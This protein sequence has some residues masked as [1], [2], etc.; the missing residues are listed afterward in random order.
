MANLLKWA[1]DRAK[2]VE[3]IAQTAEHGVSRAAAQVNPLD[4]GR[5]WQNNAP[6]QA[7]QGSV[8]QQATHNGL[9]NV[10]GNS[11]VKPAARI[12]F[13][14][15][16]QAYN[17]VVAPTFKLPKMS[18]GQAPAGHFATKQLG[19]TGKLS[20]SAGDII[21]S[22]A[23][24]LMPGS[25]KVVTGAFE[26]VLP[27][28]VP[29]IAS[30]AIANSGVG[31]VGGGVNNVGTQLSSGN[32]H[33]A[34]DIPKALEQGAKPG[35]LL[36]FGGTLAAPVLKAGAVSARPVIKKAATQASLANRTTA[37]DQLTL[38]DL[39]N[40]YAGT[41]P[42]KPAEYSKTIARARGVGQRHGVDITS[43][44]Q[45]DRMNAVNSILDKV[46]KENRATSE[47]G[48]AKAGDIIPDRAFGKVPAQSPQTLRTSMQGKS[49]VSR[50]V[51]SK[52]SIHPNTIRA[53]N[54]LKDNSAK[55]KADY[56]ARVKKE[57]GAENVVSGDAAKFI[58]PGFKD[59]SANSLH[60]HDPASKFAKEHYKQLLADP[61][62]KHKPV[63]IMSGGTGAGKTSALKR[64]GINLN[65][66]AAVVDTNLAKKTSA[67][68]RVTP[69]INSGRK[70][71]IYHV[72]REPVDAY[73]NGVIKRAYNGH[74]AGRI[75]TPSIHA[76]THAGSIANRLAD[77]FANH[78]NVKTSVIDNTS[79][80]GGI[81]GVDFLKEL[82]YTKTKIESSVNKA[83]DQ[84]RNEGKI[85][86]EQY[87]QLKGQETL[88]S[89]DPRRNGSNVAQEPST[90]H[91]QVTK[92]SLNAGVPS[93]K[94]NLALPEIL[95]QKPVVKQGRGVS[96]TNEISVAKPRSLANNTTKAPKGLTQS[97]QSSAEFSPEFKVAIS[98][99]KNPSKLAEKALV[100]DSSLR[101]L[102]KATNDVVET[103]AKPTRQLTDQDAAN[104][105][106]VMKAQDTKGNTAAA[107]QIHDLL[108]GHGEQS[109]QFI[110]AFK[111]VGNRTPEGML[112]GARK[113]L[114]KAGIT[115][116]KDMETSIKQQIN[117]I[118]KAK[119]GSQE[120]DL[121]VHNLISHVNSFIPSSTGDRLV[122]FWRAGLLTSPI[123]TAGNLIGNTGEAIV[124][125]AW[126]NPVG[127][128]ADLAQSLI[129]GKRTKTMAGGQVSG[130]AKG[131]ADSKLYLK[132]G[133]D[134][135]NP[136]NKFEQRRDLNYST[137]KVGKA[138]GTYV[139][140]VYR[141][142]GAEDKPFRQAAANQAAGDLAKADAI[143]LGLKG[144]EREAYIA[145]ARSNPEWKPQTFKTQNTSQ[146]AG[147]F[148]VFG[149]E[150][151]LG[152]AAAALKNPAT[153]GG[154]TLPTSIAQFIVP[155]SQVPASIA[156]RILHRSDLGATEVINQIMRIRHGL[157]YDQR[158]VSE[159]IGNGT[160]GPAVIGAGYALSKTGNITGNYPT[161][162]KEQELW[163][164]QGKQ[165]NSVKIGD[166]WYSMNYLQ[167]F[168]AL[169]GIGAQA[170]KDD[171]AG[172][173]P[174][175]I[176]AN[177]TA[178][179]AKS[180]EGQSFLQ[181]VN[182][183]LT[184]VNDPQR[185]AQ[186]YA[187]QTI[188]SVVPNFIRTAARATDPNQRETKG[189]VPSLKGTIPGVR[190]SLPIKQDLFG[191][192]MKA[193]DTP[194][195]Q[196][197]NPLRP[198]KVK[199][200]P[201]VNEL[202][203]L[204]DAGQGIIP[205]QYDKSAYGGKKGT[206]LTDQQVR[207]LQS[208]V[209]GKTYQAYKDTINDP[210]YAALSDEQK[211][212]ALAKAGG[213]Q[214]DAFK[215]DFAVKNNIPLIKKASKA[216]ITI[217]NGGKTDPFSKTKSSTS[218][219]VDNNSTPDAEYKTALETYNQNKS[220]YTDGQ[221]IKAEAKLSK[222]KIGSTY[223][224]NIRDLYS[225][226]KSDIY[227]YITTNKD[228][229][230]I[231]DKLK[232]YDQ[233][234]YDSG[235]TSTLKFRTGF[236]AATKKSGTKSTGTKSRK[237]TSTKVSASKIPKIKTFKQPKVKTFKV[238]KVKAK[239]LKV[240]SS[241]VA[242]N[243][244]K[245]PVAKK[246]IA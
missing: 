39:S 146:A 10:V 33:S 120:H 237:G 40:H 191:R 135:N 152:K 130:A 210:R 6:Q 177:A 5:T 204:Q 4:N 21:T 114:K 224:K 45:L 54:Y 7:H 94:N 151:A 160:F 187:D 202:A 206:P 28:V 225:L 150:T 23:N 11:I 161:D 142:L 182:G 43:G 1:Q 183:L 101:N 145:Q 98:S 80:S 197:F 170:Q 121:A 44:S 230:A 8:V 75:V 32:I 199:N 3:H 246:A 205:T 96:Q 129:T 29:K 79:R 12:P 82:G 127:A 155:F 179:A 239:K 14:V 242:Y 64:S 77:E 69:A 84:L 157:P 186:K 148:A 58:I 110:N 216:S 169:M 102:K 93:T 144:Q 55:A 95:P 112:Y 236:A 111:L 30:R 53:A 131:I 89:T 51:S 219:A 166:R 97:I 52:A 189:I 68:S 233:A 211:K 116:T 192:N 153:Y 193:V 214:G 72:H 184:A 217:L 125:N 46:K 17:S 74:E 178:T 119:P 18:V 181:G 67:A 172:K 35:A 162:H 163:R 62:T 36:G 209:G 88:Q 200:D 113:V 243:L 25:S 49:Q 109:G 164:A 65:D 168:G 194:L 24:L 15:A 213:D 141:T 105:I 231:A 223:D 173:T 37:S 180:V 190:E 83:L 16:N 208:E 221:R 159:A 128:A 106:A 174:A 99:T 137:S 27:K 201:I 47:R 22:G 108:A 9:T 71:D 229:K 241:K 20:Q 234:L 226:S 154:R 2:N 76:D 149:N 73:V 158:A 123:T 31:A 227:S 240:P 232:T 195:N 115:I 175:Q 185:G 228:G 86:N 85:T 91:L 90:Q 215:R 140:T 212:A 244:P 222:L 107:Q 92:T 132:T 78:P 220:T 198:N 133:F 171:V 117:D 38:Q 57:F 167:P 61:N 176:V 122:N 103:L 126:S 34:K 70:V 81:H 118:R 48:G 100:A 235:T 60:Y 87:N 59:N 66:Y 42:L 207:N 26:H 196:A 134:P 13:N 156:M 63:L 143:N 139:N 147:A 41:R 104:A 19:A 124:R 218:S 165:P 238:A 56:L 245:V 136:L 203:R 50:Q 138:T 188:S